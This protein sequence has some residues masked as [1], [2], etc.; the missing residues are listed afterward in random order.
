[1]RVYNFH[2]RRIAAPIEAVGAVIDTLASADDRLWPWEHFEPMKLDRP[3]Q[4]GASGGH[5]PVRYTTV[6]YRPGRLAVFE[7]DATSGFMKGFRGRHWFEAIAIDTNTTEL[8]HMLWADVRGLM[9]LAWRVLVET[10][11]DAT[12]EAAL[13]K[14]ELATTGAPS[15]RFA[16]TPGQKFWKSLTGEQGVLDKEKR[17]AEWLGD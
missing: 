17:R 16:L 14:A 8:R 13:A 9:W 7:F 6:E 5:G 2:C 10:L 11:H 4:Q 3:L 1:M 15:T 12:V